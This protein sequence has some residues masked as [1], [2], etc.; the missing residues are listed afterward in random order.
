MQWTVLSYSALLSKQRRLYGSLNQRLWSVCFRTFL[1]FSL[2]AYRYGR[3]CIKWR[4]HRSEKAPRTID[5]YSD[6]VLYKLWN[7]WQTPSNAVYR[8][9]QQEPNQSNNRV[10]LSIWCFSQIGEPGEITTLE[11][12]ETIEESIYTI[13]RIQCKDTCIFNVWCSDMHI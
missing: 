2:K 7:S 5:S 12:I 1:I 11:D 13:L 4:Y 10:R 8:P 3:G 6:S 9:L